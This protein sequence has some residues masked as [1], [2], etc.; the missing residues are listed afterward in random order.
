M[1]GMER[2]MRSRSLRISSRTIFRAAIVS[3]IV[4]GLS[5][6]T[7]AQTSM[8]GTEQLPPSVA[9]VQGPAQSPT[10]P[11]FPPSSSPQ[12]DLNSRSKNYDSDPYQNRGTPDQ[13]GNDRWGAIAFTADG[14]YA[15]IWKMPSK[16][17]AEVE[18]AK[19]CSEY[20]RGRC[21]IV[22]FSGQQ[23]VALASFNGAYRGRRW[24]L[25]YTDGGVTYPEAQ[26]GAMARCNA[27]ERTRGRCLP[28]TTACA[29][30]R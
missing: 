25:A 3:A 21:E 13:G 16:A 18:V 5:S 9:P 29:D 4:F 12:T 8:G 23:C 17:E 26:N 14:S 22:S 28:R 6:G 27:D 2:I 1:I 11:N 10:P 20:G 7:S 24:N 15:S 19:K 30:G